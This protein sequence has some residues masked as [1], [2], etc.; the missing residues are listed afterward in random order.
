MNQVHKWDKHIKVTS[1]WTLSRRDGRF[2]KTPW[3]QVVKYLLDRGA[4][5]NAQIMTSSLKVQH[6][7]IDYHIQ[8]V[9]DIKSWWL[10]STKEYALETSYDVMLW[11]L[12]NE[13]T[14]TYEAAKNH[15]RYQVTCGIMFSFVIS[16]CWIASRTISI[17]TSALS[18][19]SESQMLIIP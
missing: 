5:C 18:V 11:L 17:L 16:D 12:E 7:S 19:L 4:S 14:E 10:P 6:V 1:R 8:L 2:S 3:F 9:V 15:H 13:N